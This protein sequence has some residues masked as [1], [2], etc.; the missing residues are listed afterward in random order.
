MCIV[1]YDNS[2]RRFK[3]QNSWGTQN[4]DGMIYAD[5]D[6][7]NEAGDS[8]YIA[9]DMDGVS[10]KPVV[11]LS[12]NLNFGNVATGTQ[13]GRTLVIRNSGNATL[14]VGSIDC[15]AGFSADWNGGDISAGESRN[16][17]V[18]FRPAAAASYSGN[19]SVASNADNGTQTVS[20]S[21]TGTQRAEARVELSGGLNFGNVETG[22]SATGT[23]TVRNTGNA[24]L[25]VASVQC[26]AG[27]RSDWNGGNISVGSSRNVTITFSPASDG[28]YDGNVSVTSNAVNGTQSVSVSGTGT[29][30]QPTFHP[31][32]GEY[33]GLTDR[34]PFI[35]SGHEVYGDNIKVSV[36][37]YSSTSNIIT[38]RIRKNSGTFTFPG[39][40][41]V[42]SGDYCGTV[43]KSESYGTGNE[44]NTAVTIPGRTGTYKYTIVIKSGNSTGDWFYSGTV[45]VDYR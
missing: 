21:G 44:I 37:S 31:A 28:Y 18:T 40:V 6:V 41:Y 19:V 35:C 11:E 39:T 22:S 26:P 29:R 4:S 43:V 14:T 20:V 9:Y 13:T 23:L 17:T 36:S 33:T 8:Y 42:K 34:G 10:E 12:G 3:I 24:T 30:R 38:F 5:Y 25:T 2:A 1:G 45:T 7:L 15:P 32:M 27:F 16:V